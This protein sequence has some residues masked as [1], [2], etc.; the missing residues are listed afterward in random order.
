MLSISY[1]GIQKKSKSCQMLKCTFFFA[2][3]LLNSFLTL[4]AQSLEES[5]V[6]Q[7]GTEGYKCYRIPAIVCAPNGD[8]LAFAEARRTDCGD[9]GDVRIVLKR[10]TN[11]GKTWNELQTVAENGS[12]QAG[13]QAPV[14]DMTDPKFPKGRLFLFYNTGMVSE[15]DNRN[16]KGIREVWY[17]TSID[18][19]KTWSAAV[20]ITIFV[21]K[22]NRPEQNPNYNFKED[23][24]SYANTPGH[25]LQIKKGK[26]KG[27]IFVPANHSEGAPQPLFRDYR[28]HGF[29][30]DDHGKSWKIAPNVNYASSNE[31]TAAETADGSILMNCRN[32]SGDV[33][34]RLQAFSKN[35]GESWDS[36]VV[37]KSLNDPVCEGSLI[38]F[39]TKKRQHV[40]LFS[41]LNSQSKRENLTVNVSYDDGKTWT[42]KKEICK[43]SAAY[44]DLV[45]QKNNQI[46]I[47][48]EKDDYSKIVFTNF[49]YD[50]LV[51]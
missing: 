5:I 34:Y 39:Q 12:Y 29:Y 2:I 33:K 16:G 22:P 32:Q 28:A 21:S 42:I 37:V 25:A 18:N 35:A 6:F 51:K 23:W 10:S 11:N 46:G 26:Y 31:S 8:L 36:V 43:S 44:S 9:F 24:R 48:Y 20:N 38:D 27:R 13:N 15:N 40:L 3:L 30:T 7:N 50:W 1:F 47:L 14:F 45:I 19:G 17:K 49:D 4:Q 41:N